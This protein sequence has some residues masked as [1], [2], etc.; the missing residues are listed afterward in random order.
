MK[1]VRDQSLIRGAQKFEED[2]LAEIYDCFSPGIYRYAM[3]LLGDSDQAEEC[4]SETFS[5]FLI[6]L[7]NGG[8]PKDYLQAYLYRIAHNWITD[9]YR[10][11]PPP[12]LPLDLEFHQDPAGEPH[13][14]VA[15]DLEYQQVRTALALLTPDQ[16][17]V[18]LLK[19]LEDWQN[20]EIAQAL[21]KPVGAIKALQHRAIASLRRIFLKQEEMRG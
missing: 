19:Y 9:F 14:V 21:N 16:R 12:E 7:K 8:G 5:R 4:V 6:A 1:T 15:D 20:D 11:Q 13:Q 18:I 2:A 10:R 17:Q 3:R